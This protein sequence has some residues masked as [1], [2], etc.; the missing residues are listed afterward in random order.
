MILRSGKNPGSFFVEQYTTLWNDP[1]KVSISYHITSFQC[2]KDNNSCIVLVSKFA[3]HQKQWLSTASF[4]YSEIGENRNKMVYLAENLPA[5]TI[6][7]AKP[8]PCILHAFTFAAN[9]PEVYV[10]SVF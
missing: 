1:K 2:S 8:G 3:R 6:N 10:L 4:Q 9:F 7:N 5:F